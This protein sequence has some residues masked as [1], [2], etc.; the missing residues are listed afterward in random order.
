MSAAVLLQI[1]NGEQRARR[2]KPFRLFFTLT[3]QCGRKIQVYI[4]YRVSIQGEVDIPFHLRMGPITPLKEPIQGAIDRR[5]P[6]DLRKVYRVTLMPDFAISGY[7]EVVGKAASYTLLPVGVY[8][9]ELWYDS[10][11]LAKLP[12]HEGLW[13]GVTNT[14]KFKLQ[15]LP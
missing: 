12:Y 5:R 13:L 2:A 9:G 7:V 11:P 15:V 3:N 10:R 4:P 14:V 6:L 8:Q 1:R